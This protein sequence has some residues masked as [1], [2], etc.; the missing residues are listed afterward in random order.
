MICVLQALFVET[1]HSVGLCILMF[2][3]LPNLD[4][5]I[6]S[7]VM[8]N[9]GTIPGLLKIAYPSRNRLPRAPNL[10]ESKE[11]SYKMCTSITMNLIIAVLH[12]GGLGTTSY[13]ILNPPETFVNDETSQNQR[14]D[15]VILLVVACVFISIGWWENFVPKG[16]DYSNGLPKL[17][18]YF[19]QS[20][21][22]I[23]F[24]T[25]CWKIV[26]SSCILPVI[27]AYFICGTECIDFI[28]FKHS[29]DLEVSK[30]PSIMS[31]ILTDGSLLDSC[32]TFHKWF[33]FM[34]AFVY[35]FMN[36]LCYKIGKAACKIVA[37]QLAFGLPIAIATP[38][39]LAILLEMMSSSKTGNSAVGTFFFGTCEIKFP[40]WVSDEKNPILHLTEGEHF[41][42]IWPIVV[43]GFLSYFSLLII[44]NYIWSPKKE[45]LQPTEK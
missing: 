4:P 13:H 17:K 40:Y 11:N 9:V 19:M 10:A 5:V 31:T 43:G 37:Q 1:V 24:I 14:R 30:H 21:S 35:I 8:L 39:A 12:V 42:N 38:V 20:R 44:T 29:G 27:Y 26:L 33:P 22:K 36:G 32:A 3:V 25:M 16:R 15:I 45:R 6:S 23:V 28:Y 18:R 7:I 34:I 41:I 2:I